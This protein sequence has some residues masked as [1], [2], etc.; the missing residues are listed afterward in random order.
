WHG[1]GGCP[2]CKSNEPKDVVLWIGDISIY[3]G[4]DVDYAPWE[5]I[6]KWM[7]LPPPKRILFDGIEQTYRPYSCSRRQLARKNEL[8]A[9]DAIE[10]SSEGLDQ[11]YDKLQKLI[12]Q[13]EILGETISQVD[14]E[15]EVSKNV[16][17]SKWK[18]QTLIWRNKPNLD[19]LSMDDLYNN[20]KI[21]ET[22]VKG[23]L[24]SNQNSLEC[25]CC[26]F[27]ISLQF[28]SSVCPQLNDED[29]QQIDSNDLEE[30]DLKWQMAMSPRENRNREP[31]RRNMIVETTKTKALV[32]QDGLGYDWSDQ[33][34]EGPTNFALMAYTS[35]SSSRCLLKQ[36]FRKKFEKAEKER[37][38]LK[39]TLEKFGNSSKNLRKLLEIQVSDKFKTGVG[40]DSQVV[41][42]HVFDSQENES[43]T[44]YLG[45]ANSEAI[46]SVS[47]PKSVGEHL[48]KTRYLIGEVVN[49]TGFT[50]NPQL[51]LQEKGVIDSGCSRHMTRNKSY[52][53]DYEEIDGGFVTFEGDPKGSRIT[54]KDTKCVVLS[55][56][57]KLLDENHVLLRVPRKDNMYSVDLKNIVPS[58]GLTCLFAKATLDE[59]NLWHRRLGHINF[60]TLNKLVRG[61]LVRGLPSKIFENN[62]T[63]VACQKGKKHKAS[64]KTKINSTQQNGVAERKNRTLIEAARTMLADSK[65]PTTFWAEAVNTACYVQN[66]VLVIKPHNKTPYELFLEKKPVLSFMRPFGCPVTILNTIDHLGKFDGK[67][68]EGFFVGYS[69]SSKAYMDSPNA[70]FKPSG[71]EEKIDSEHQ[72]NEDIYGCIDDPNMPNLE[73]I[74]YSD[75]DEKVGVEADMNNL[76][77]NVH[78]SPIPT[79]RV[80][81]DHPLEQIIGDINSAPQ[82]RRMTKNVTEHEVRTLIDLP[83]QEGPLFPDKVYKVE[84]ALYGLHQAPRA[85]YETLSTYLLENGFRRGTIDKTLFIKKNKGDILLLQGVGVTS[86]LVYKESLCVEFEQMMHKDSGEFY[87][88]LTFF[89]GLQ[90]KQKDDGIFIS[91][92]KYVADILKK[93]DFATIKTSNTPIKTNKAFFKDEE[94][95]DVDVHLYRSMIGS[96]MYLTASRPD[97]MFAVCACA[98]FQVTPKVSHLHVVKRIFKYLKGQ[99]KLGLWYLRDSPFDLEAFSDSDYAGASLDKKSTTG[100]CQ[101]LSKRLISWQCKKQTIVANSTTEAENPVFHSKTKHIEIR[102]H[103]IRDSYE[104]KLI[105]VIKIHIDHNVADLLIKA[106]DVSSGPIHLVA[107]KTVYKE[108]EDR[109]GRATTTSSSLEAEQDSEIGVNTGVLKLMLL[110]LKLNANVVRLNLLLPVL[111][112]AARRSLTTVRHKLMLTGITS[113][114]WDHCRLIQLIGYADTT[115][116]DKKKVIISETSIRSDLKLDDTDGIDCLPTT[117]V[118]AELERMGIMASANICL[119]T[120]QKFNLS[121][122]IFDNMVKNLD[123]G[124]KFLMYPRFVQVF[125]DKQVE[126]MSKHKGV[127]VTPSHTKKVFANMKRPCKGFSGRVTPLFSTMM[128]QATE[129][130]GRKQRKDSGPTEPVTDEAHVSTPSYDPPQSGEDSMQLFELMNLCTSLQDKVLDLEKAKTAQAKE[131]TSLKKIVKQLE[132]RRKSRPSGLRRLRKVG[133]TSRVESFNDASLGAQEDAS[134]QRRKIEDLDADAEVT[135]VNKT[136]EM[137]DDNLMFDTGVLE[138]QELEFEKVKEPVVSVATTTKSIPV[139]AAE[140][141]TTTSA[142]VEITDELTLAQTLIEIKTAKPKPVTT[143]ATTVTSI[144]PRA[145]GIIFHDQE[146]Q[147]P[148]STKTF[149][150]SQSQVKDK[151]KGIMVEPKVPLKKKDRV[152]LNEEM[153]RNLEA[154]L[155][156][157]LIEEERLARQK[158]EEAN[159]KAG[160]TGGGYDEIEKLFNK[161]MKRVN[162]FV[163][164]NSEVVKGSETRTEESYKRAR[165]ELESDMSKKQKIDEHVEAEKDDDPEEEEMKKAY[166]G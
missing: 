36:I 84:K 1:P 166:G 42:S 159:S 165:D 73:E 142:S 131:I 122:Y 147:V 128:V 77:T 71:E 46:D 126:G 25:A 120:N 124:I 59:S 75:H 151:G 50:R 97:I 28:Q 125:L 58:G 14:Y 88:E 135:L 105:H 12:S 56:D 35:S 33:A 160:R 99:H 152:A 93:F 123:G 52:L 117:T 41:N 20:L 85:W 134:K 116:V 110:S 94:D 61:N 47:K 87:E 64:C 72:E 66:R 9:R 81:K 29:L 60:K 106:F 138:E 49:E 21:Y 34:E 79:T 150:S 153:A 44:V 70:R 67:A 39:L 27:L 6:V 92:D 148:A 15:S 119:A 83:W 156:A 62:H 7:R 136:Q 113:Y 68:D 74:V 54:S 162:I 40:F 121:K 17:P 48:L 118:F 3:A 114:C 130:M 109:M 98:S 57:F 146:E 103:F 90:V 31:V 129:D 137:N 145:K 111:V 13:L 155:Q 37:D 95:E 10:K 11:T 32:A 30:M 4:T 43:H 38:D 96:L 132:K 100:G 78:V 158:E 164:M 19:T 157:E 139:S 107:D 144:R 24:R 154:R 76:A 26:I 65:L 18:T 2:R 101:F 104:K 22:E 53:S 55:P 91:Q 163:D 63:C 127:Y 112:Y 8:K 23:S 45:A 141:V 149:S 5:L 16:L 102:H 82:T 161:E 143:V 89:L 115:L 80:Y 86:S 133:S 108:W 51:E 69:T 140:V